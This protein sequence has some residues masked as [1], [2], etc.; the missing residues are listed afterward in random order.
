M[1]DVVQNAMTELH[2]GSWPPLSGVRDRYR[3]VL[4]YGSVA[5]GDALPTSDVDVLAVGER[6]CERQEGRLSLTVY[7][8]QQLIELARAGSLFVLHLKDEAIVLRDDRGGFERIVH[9]WRPPNL[10][11]TIAGMRAAAAVLD[12]PSSL[13]NTLRQAL[14]A[15]AVFVLRSVAYLRC[16]ERGAPAF[17]AARVAAV[18]GDSDLGAFLSRLREPRRDPVEVL[19]TARSLIERHLGGPP[20]NPFGS[21]EALAV[22]CH[23]Q[24]PLASTLALRVATGRRPLHYTVGPATWWS[25]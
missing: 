23:R 8:E 18:L 21:L 16:Y 6:S 10:E 20:I 22:S 2:G 11:R 25:P 12:V 15:A 1:G 13:E 14:A 17:A 5:R 3:T 7:E 4:I 9:A 19:R 24:F